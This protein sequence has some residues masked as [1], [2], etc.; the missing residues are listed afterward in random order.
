M[1]E[2]RKGETREEGREKRKGERR[3]REGKRGRAR[4]AN[5]QISH[6]D[7]HTICTIWNTADPQTTNTKSASIQGPTGGFSPS[8]L[9]SD[10]GTLPRSVTFFS[11]RWFAMRM[12]CFDT[13]VGMEIVIEA[14]T[15]MRAVD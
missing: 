14:K 12:R 3:G 1:R 2:K 13:I 4:D 10:G 7:A 9:F 8:P 6:Y 11:A 5:P 15:E